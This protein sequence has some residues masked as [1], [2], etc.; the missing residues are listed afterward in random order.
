[1]GK[2]S[3]STGNV[4]HWVGGIRGK[5][6]TPRI[7]LGKG[8]SGEKASWEEVEESRLAVIVPTIYEA[9]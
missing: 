7:G 6:E 2:I 3:P 9:R 5:A 8:S 1:M 4:A